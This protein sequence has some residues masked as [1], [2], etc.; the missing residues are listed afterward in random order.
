[1]T[2]KTGTELPSD[3]VKS[4]RTVE[5]IIGAIVLLILAV[6]FIPKILTGPVDA[7]SADK[8]NNAK[9]ANS[10]NAQ[11]A[12]GAASSSNN[13]GTSTANSNADRRQ[14]QAL[15]KGKG[16]I[17]VLNDNGRKIEPASVNATA[18]RSAAGNSGNSSTSSVASSRT[19]NTR[20]SN[21]Q[22][23]KPNESNQGINTAAA[24]NTATTRHAETAR[25]DPTTS[26]QAPQ[27]TQSSQ[28]TQRFQA[29]SPA[30]A[31]EKK[32]LIQL[33]SFSKKSNADAV[34]ARATLANLNAFVVSYTNPE[35]QATLHRVRVKPLLTR[36]EAQ[37][38][39]EDLKKDFTS[40]GIVLAK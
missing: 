8:V 34:Q 3:D 29:T 36:A 37:A 33:G 38:R 1:M 22:P 30:P 21:P 20:Q 2:K 7:D 15:S 35:T 31:G 40:A 11:N 26:R 16:T 5:R 32:W 17:F 9:L 23:N 18:N 27:T 6:I 4:D 39:V 12:S 14:Q 13:A 10:L 28:A 19:A 25:T 24:A